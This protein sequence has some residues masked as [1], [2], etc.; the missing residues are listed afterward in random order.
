MDSENYGVIYCREDDE[1]RVYCD[2][3]DKLCI[4][5]F[6]KNNFKSKTYNFLLLHQIR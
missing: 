2:I 3:C 6:Y 1:Y 5:R 4:Q